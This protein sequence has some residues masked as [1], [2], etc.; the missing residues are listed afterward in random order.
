M[1]ERFRGNTKELFTTF[2]ETLKQFRQSNSR[3][4]VKLLAATGWLIIFARPY[5]FGKAVGMDVS[6]WAFILFIPIISV[7]EV[8]PLSVMGLG[9][10][11]A[12]ILFLFSAMGVA[13]EQMIALSAMMLVLSLVPQATAG[14]LIAL[15]QKVRDNEGTSS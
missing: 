6:W 2:H 3:W 12:T 4:T 1:P 13:H 7:V 5:F 9:T 8:L 10:R 14:Y 15:S 11:D